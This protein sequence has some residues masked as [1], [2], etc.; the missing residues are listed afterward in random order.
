M[1]LSQ[2]ERRINHVRSKLDNAG[3]RH[4][5]AEE[6]VVRKITALLLG[7]LLTGCS[8]EAPSGATAPKEDDGVVERAP[9]EDEVALGEPTDEAGYRKRGNNY[10]SQGASHPPLPAHT[11]APP[12][13]P[14]AP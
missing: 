7:L 2:F 12:A 13:P 5:T 10:F 9:E 3:S 4:P 6:R 8:A 14:D 1:E 11:P